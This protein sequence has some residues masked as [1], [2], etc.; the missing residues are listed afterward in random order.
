MKGCDIFHIFEK[1]EKTFWESIKTPV[2]QK[3]KGNRTGH[4]EK[5]HNRRRNIKG[6]HWRKRADK[7]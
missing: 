4:L 1:W 2:G 5:I 6:G 7:L 3:I